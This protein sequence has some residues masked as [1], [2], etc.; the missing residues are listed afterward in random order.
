MQQEKMIQKE[1]LLMEKERMH[2]Q[3]K[4]KLESELKSK[5]LLYIV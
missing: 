2:T 5:I 4:E 1:V 3:E